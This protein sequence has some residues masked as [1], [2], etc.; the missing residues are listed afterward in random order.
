MHP[1]LLQEYGKKQNQHIKIKR[2][3]WGSLVKLET[4]W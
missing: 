4:F 1:P 2:Q 3:D